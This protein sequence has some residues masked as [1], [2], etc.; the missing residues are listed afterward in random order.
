[1]SS[2]TERVS[3]IVIRAW[4]EAADD[5]LRAR[6][7]WTL[8]VSRSGEEE[9]SAAASGDEILGAVCEWLDAF[10]TAPPLTEW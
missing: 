5:S 8:D 3:V 4:T 7:T 2:D 6:I 9:T 10:R 1:M